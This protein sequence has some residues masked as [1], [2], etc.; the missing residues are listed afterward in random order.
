VTLESLLAA[1]PGFATRVTVALCLSNASDAA[2]QMEKRLVETLSLGFALPLL[3]FGDL[4]W[5]AAAVFFGMLTG[6]CAAGTLAERFGHKRLLVMMLYLEA[7]A[8]VATTAA[9]GSWH[10]TLCRYISGVAIGAAVPPI[11]ALAEELIHPRKRRHRSL[12]LIASSFI[13]GSVLV[14]LLAWPL[15]LGWTWQAFYAST[16]LV[17]LL[18]AFL[19]SCWIPESPSFLQQQ[20]RRAELLG[21]LQ[22]FA[23]LRAAGPAFRVAQ[24]ANDGQIRVIEERSISGRL[25]LLRTNHVVLRLA[26]ICFSIAFAWYGLSTWLL[27]LFEEVG[28]E[29]RYLAAMLYALS[30]VPGCVLAM[31]LLQFIEPPKLLAFWLTLTALSCLSI[32]HLP[33]TV[34]GD[35]LNGRT[36]EG[37]DCPCSTELRRE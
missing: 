19:V 34:L 9:R 30:G 31:L 28:L 23:G 29:H 12:S 13:S 2:S 14:S 27:Q 21:E 10:L 4:R 33:K 35:L 15:S 11:F 5:P 22:H 17:P 20:G 1:S 8:A 26:A 3:N 7:L 24:E 37:G 6:G 36:Q 18:N 16:G 32:G 25:Q